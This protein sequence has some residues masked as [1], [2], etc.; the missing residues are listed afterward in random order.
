MADWL[1][2][3]TAATAVPAWVGMWHARRAHREVA[4]PRGQTLYAHVGRLEADVAALREDVG[5]NP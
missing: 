1:A 5:E 3:A 4:T 2:V